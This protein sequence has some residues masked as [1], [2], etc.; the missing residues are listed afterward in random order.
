MNATCRDQVE[1]NSLIMLDNKQNWLARQAQTVKDHI[2]KI[3]NYTPGG[4]GVATA[5][6]PTTEPE[7]P[8]IRNRSPQSE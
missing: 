4:N 1:I 7:V 5:A 6:T 3:A 2:G 8:G